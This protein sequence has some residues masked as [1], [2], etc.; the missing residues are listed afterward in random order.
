MNE[1]YLLDQPY[2]AED[3][4]CLITELDL[5]CFQYKVDRYGHNPIL[6]LSRTH[7]YIH[8]NSNNRNVGHLLLQVYKPNGSILLAVWTDIDA[9]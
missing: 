6:S 7:P 4:M 2:L 3:L 5:L 9:S 1:T 8:I